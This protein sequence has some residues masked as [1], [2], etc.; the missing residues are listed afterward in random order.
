MK[1][2][3][4]GG[5]GL[6]G[7]ACIRALKRDGHTVVG[8][9]RSASQ[10]QR[11]DPSID[12]IT[13]DIARTTAPEWKTAL[14]DIDVIVNA[15]GIL[16]DGAGN[17]LTAIHETAVANIAEALQN[18]KT[19]FIQISAAGVSKTASTAFFRSKA[20]G[21][22]A[23]IDSQIDWIILRPTVV[24]SPQAYGGTAFL[25][26]CAAYPII[27]PKTLENSPMQTVAVTDV[28]NAVTLA[29][30]GKIPARTIADLTEE[31][32]HTMQE[33]LETIRRWQGFPAWKR[34]I[35]LPYP[36]IQL[37]AKC[38]DAMGWLGWR[39]PLRSTALKVMEDGVTGDPTTWTNVGGI[40]CKSL[41]ETLSEMPATTQD[42]WFSRL[43]LL[44]PIAVATLAI[45]WLLTG[46]IALF[47]KE[48]AIALLLT[49]GFPEPL[50]K[51]TVIGGSIIDITL[52]AAILIRRYARPACL[53]MAF[54]SI[55]YLIG[56]TIGAPDLWLD[57]IGPL[58]KI[59]PSITLALFLAA[60]IEER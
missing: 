53:G 22:Q 23:L 39:I 15:S 27:T 41:N 47:T 44:L 59:L 17:S 11:S 58:L 6:I 37:T 32:S 38:A 46:I 54:M 28:A 2:A 4:L 55:A 56:G 10:G 45:F 3:V 34:G 60:I 24:L 8:V 40:P 49:H 14:H 51:A 57:P 16:Q 35:R 25:R 5:Y 20:R 13:L 12:W 36:L 1:I 48:Q 29:A 43:F 30:S 33:I 31:T 26:A 52:G 42:R 18:T 50:A 9:G 7:S 19:R 21:D